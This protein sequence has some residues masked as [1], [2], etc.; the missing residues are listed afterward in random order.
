M[1]ASPPWPDAPAGYGVYVHF[2]WCRARCAY[3]AFATR[4]AS[5]PPSGA[6]A[7]AVLAEWAR[8]RADLAG[9]PPAHSLY[10]GGGTPSL[11]DPADLARIVAAVPLRDDAEVTLEANPGTVKRDGAGLPDLRP[12]LDA[13]VTRLSIGIQTFDDARL[14]RLGRLHTAEDARALARAAARAPLRSWSADL[15]FG[16]PGQD[17]AALDRDLAALLA[18]DPPHVSVYGLTWEPGTPLDRER[19]AGRLRPLDDDAWADAYERVV[20]TLEAAGLRRYEVSNFARP[21]HRARHNEAVWRAGPYVGLGPAAHGWLPDGRRTANPPAWEDWLAAPDL[22]GTRPEPAE[23]ALDLVLS[24]LR[25]VD[26]TDLDAL[27]A[28]TGLAGRG[29]LL[30]DAVVARVCAAL[31]PTP[32]RASDMLPD[33]S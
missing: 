3:C 17:A 26:G 1:R 23:E 24:T 31:A 12:F 25:H 22:E 13:G 9:Q 30:A 29:W 19:R 8:R 21:G 7:E 28:A 10:F 16:L 5:D 33:Q 27:A 18:L 14:A 4:A 32:R 20:A 11:A 2:P 15:I 6:W